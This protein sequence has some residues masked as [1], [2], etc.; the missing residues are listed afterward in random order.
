MSKILRITKDEVIELL[1]KKFK[2]DNIKFMR[3][4]GSEPDGEVIDDFEYIE[5]DLKEL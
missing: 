3:S 2:I 5:G 4:N 1:K